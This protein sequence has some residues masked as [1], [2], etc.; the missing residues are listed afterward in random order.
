MHHRALY[1]AVASCFALTGCPDKAE[2]P[3]PKVAVAPA[4]AAPKPPEAPV[5][6]P[7][8]SGPDARATT[9]VAQ[10]KSGAAGPKPGE[11]GCKKGNCKVTITV[12]GSPPS[13]VITESPNPLGVHKDNKDDDI[14]WTIAGNDYEFTD[15]GIAWK[16]P[17]APFDLK[18]KNGNQ[19]QWRD[20]NPE[21]TP[22]PWEYSIE[23]QKKNGGP[24]CPKKDPTVINGVEV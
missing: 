7:A 2:P 9:Q 4:A 12:T 20:R 10:A 6:P 21:T 13:C 16:K 3:K 14:K 11:P 15:N 24:K 5:A 17:N 8:S 22:T 19:F 18:S 23:V 1:L